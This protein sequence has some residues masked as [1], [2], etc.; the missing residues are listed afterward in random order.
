MIVLDGQST[1]RQFVVSGTDTTWGLIAT[2][3]TFELS[4]LRLINGGGDIRTR[5]EKPGKRPWTVAIQD[6]AKKNHYPD[7][8]HRRDGAV[9][10]SGNYE[11]FY[12]KEKMF[13]HI[14]DPHSGA[15][16]L[17]ASSVSVKARTTMDADALS[18]S[19]FVMNPEKGLALIKQLP[20][21]DCLIVTR[22][23]NQLR[24][25]GWKSAAS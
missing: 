13:H 12:D 23:N 2:D 11:I 22:D 4:H 1:Y 18:T 10:T 5:G 24:S 16:P 25:K 15:S 6:P 3:I 14:V 8:I 17:L 21:C 20:D 7:I 9:A 19:V